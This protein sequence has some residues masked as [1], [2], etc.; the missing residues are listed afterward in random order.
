MNGETASFSE[1]GA[2]KREEEIESESEREKEGD[3]QRLVLANKN[4]KL[5]WVSTF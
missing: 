5:A 4:D 2:C 3:R 1:V